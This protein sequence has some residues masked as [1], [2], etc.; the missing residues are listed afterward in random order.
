MKLEI[1]N[2]SHLLKEVSNKLI[3]KLKEKNVDEDIIFDV[4]VGFEEAL[5]NA[6]IHGNKSMA[7]KKV[8]IETQITDSFVQI[9]VEDE[10]DGFDPDS[11][12]D[13]TLDENLLKEGGRGVYLIRHLL[14][15]VRFE[16][17]GRKVIMKKYF[18]KIHK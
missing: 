12:P 15:E 14:D 18:E 3:G 7:G 17:D 8:R 2:D 4:H 6:M 5:R 1:A 13:P 16:K 10:G 11:L 9:S